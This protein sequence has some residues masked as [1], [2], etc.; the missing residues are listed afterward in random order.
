MAG[1]K[2]AHRIQLGRESS[3]GTAVAATTIWRGIGGMLKDNRAVTMVDELVGIAL[4][5]TRAYIGMEES[6]LSM[7]AT[8]AT[9]EQLIHILEAGI[10]TVGTGASD[11][12]GS[13]KIYAY[14]VGMTSVNT[15][16]TYTIETGDNQQ[17][18]EADYCFVE[19][20]TLSGERGQAV[21]MSADWI[22]RKVSTTN[23]TGALS[24][25]TVETILA[26]RGQ[27]FI[28]AVGGTIGTTQISETLLKWELSVDT[29]WRAKYT[30]DSD[31]SGGGLEFAFAYFDRDSFKAELSVTYEHNATAVAQ[32]LLFQGPTARLV[33]I[34]IPGSLLGTAGTTYA[35]KWLII[36]AA[37]MYTEWD[38]LDAD[39]GNS[40]V[41]VTGTIG[42]DATAA[43]AL[44]ITVVNELA[45]VP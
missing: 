29:G 32:K 4:P 16:K 9:F 24:I 33:R 45:S 13:G 34:Q 15:I 10:K 3:A 18:E 30:V 27:F 25:P 7:A 41:N 31:A 21:K 19:K 38:A 42:Y 14:P 44:S 11:G 36:D 28:D 1:G 26:G 23:F 39:E 43:K 20:F 5:T 35:N 40:I 6:A 22:G 2:W 8:E 12:V 17:A 37:L